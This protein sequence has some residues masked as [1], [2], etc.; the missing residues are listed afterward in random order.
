MNLV[1]EEGPAM[2]ASAVGY[3]GLEGWIKARL[4]ATHR[5]VV[6]TVSTAVLCLLAAQRVTPAA[7]AR[8]LPAEQAG[9]GRARLTRVRR[10]WQGPPLDQARVSAA[11]IR[12]ALAVVP[13]GAPVVVAL[14]TTR[15]GA[16]EVWLAGVVVAGRTL[17]I[18]WA[19]IPY[20]WPRGRFRATTL[21]LIRRL[22]AAFPP[23]VRWTL[24]A[25][26]GFPSAALFA[27]LRQGGTDFSVRLRL[28]DWVT[29]AGVYATVADHLDAGRLA[30]GQR[31]AATIGRGRPDQPLVPGWVAVSAAV[32]PPPTHKQN[33]GTLRERAKRAK[34]HAQHRRH[35]QGRKTK[36]PSAAAQRY[37]QTWVLFTT[38]PTVQQAVAEYAKRMPI[39][40]TYRDWH[41][42]WGVRAAVVGLPTEA[43]VERL[44]GVVC[45]AYTLQ[46]QLGRRLSLDEAG[47]RRWAQ[48]T[49]TDRVSWFWCGRRLF[50]DPGYDWSAWLAQQWDRLIDPRPPALP[51]PVPDAAL[52]E[53]A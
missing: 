30:V 24:V 40:E 27:Q 16:W 17:P 45:L 3:A 32:A 37:A 48:W 26:R 29:V 5:T 11:L 14:D 1:T 49:V 46:L 2:T 36:A 9:T 12:D 35:K 18:G 8:A 7:L 39:E 25:D 10:W 21:A 34:Q 4:A 53:A 52:A 20:P 19:V 38:A 6:R 47:Q 23:G 33:P 31:S 43:M 50:D 42:G 44:I 13:A 41:S 22:Q 28:S 51:V 15:L